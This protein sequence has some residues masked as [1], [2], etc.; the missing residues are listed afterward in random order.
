MQLL[1]RN[2]FEYYPAPEQRANQLITIMCLTDGY[3]TGQ[4]FENK[5]NVS[6]TTI[7]SDLNRV[8]KK[9]QISILFD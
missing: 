6:K 1:S 2:E 8:E 9:L 7:L 5:M 3:I 4:Q